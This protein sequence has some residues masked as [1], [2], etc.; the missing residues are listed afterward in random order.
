[1]A[2]KNKIFLKETLV[3]T[4]LPDGYK[5]ILTSICL[6]IKAAQARAMSMVNHELIEVYRDVGKTIYEQQKKG[7]WGDS[8]VKKLALDL[9]KNFHGMRG[10]S[11]RNL[12]T[13]KELYVSYKDNEKLQTLSAQISWSHNVA[14]ISKC[15]DLLEREF[16]MKMSIRNGWTYRVLIHHIEIGTFEKT[17]IAQSNFDKSLPTN[18]RP[19]AALVVKD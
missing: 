5:D 6:K 3:S 2:K 12:Y 4:A 18:L 13:M 9:Q 19:E 17:M 7:A 11:Y 8:V 16:Y 10:F 14:L 15:K 1:M